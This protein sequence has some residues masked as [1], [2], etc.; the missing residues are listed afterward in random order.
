M[1]K[2]I[3][4]CREVL[5]KVCTDLGRDLDSPE[6]RP[7]VAHIRACPRCAA[8]RESLENTVALF[9]RYPV[10]RRRGAAGPKKRSRR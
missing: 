5:R 9:R 2:R 7:F 3:P 10:P 4:G 8:W 6:C 1:K